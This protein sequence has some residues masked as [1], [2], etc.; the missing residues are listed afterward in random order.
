MIESEAN[1]NMRVYEMPISQAS[2]VTD[3]GLGRAEGKRREPITSP[4]TLHLNGFPFI[5][6]PFT[7]CT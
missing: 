6:T 4:E 2:P 7:L 1:I 5:I 3:P